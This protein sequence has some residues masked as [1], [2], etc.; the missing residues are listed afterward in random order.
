MESQC[1]ELDLP[2][3]L[4]IDFISERQML[5]PVILLRSVAATSKLGHL[6]RIM[7]D[8]I[9]LVF[10]HQRVIKLPQKRMHE[11]KNVPSLLPPH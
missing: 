1:I 7:Y 2:I 3:W 10:K 5:D 6:G 11:E 8:H 9:L 4:P